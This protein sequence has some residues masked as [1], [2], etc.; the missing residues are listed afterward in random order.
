MGLMGLTLIIAGQRIVRVKLMEKQFRVT[1]GALESN[2]LL[3][4][5]C[6]YQRNQRGVRQTH[7]PRRKNRS[8]TGSEEKGWH[9]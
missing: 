5:M 9:C 8:R 2:F 6:P 4:R 1:R 3:V 7:Q